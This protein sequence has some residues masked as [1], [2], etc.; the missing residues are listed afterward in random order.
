MYGRLSVDMGPL[1]GLGSFK[2]THMYSR[3]LSLHNNKQM[4]IQNNVD[5][6]Y[7]G[8]TVLSITLSLPLPAFYTHYLHIVLIQD[9]SVIPTTP[10]ITSND[11]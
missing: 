5:V 2:Y 7:M 6:Q 10:I 8:Q 4:C 11:I 9:S 3:C 1:K